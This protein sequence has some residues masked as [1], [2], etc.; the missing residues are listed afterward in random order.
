MY[1]L[2]QNTQ[3]KVA[4]GSA[5]TT[6]QMVVTVSIVDLNITT[7]AVT[8][9]LSDII[10]P[11]NG[12]TEVTI[13]GSPAAGNIR[14]IKRIEVNNQDTV[15]DTIEFIETVSGTD[16][17]IKNPIT[18]AVNNSL[19]YENNNGWYITDADGSV[20]GSLGNLNGDVTGPSSANTVVKINGAPLGST[21]P[22]SGNVL[23]ADG[24]EWKSVSLSTISAGAYKEPVFWTTLSALPSNS[25]NNGAAG[26]GATLTA[27]TNGALSIN[28]NAVSV[29]DRI[30]VNGESTPANNGI[31]VVTQTGSSG[32]PYILTRAA[33]FDTSD[34][35]IGGSLVAEVSNALDNSANWLSVWI[36]HF[37]TIPITVGTDGITFERIIPSF[38]QRA[39]GNIFQWDSNRN[40]VGNP[41]SGDATITDT[42]V[43][44]VSGIG[45]T[46]ANL[47]RL[48]DRVFRSKLEASSAA[49]TG[50]S[51]TAYFVYL[52]QTATAIT[53]KFIEGFTPS[54]GTTSV[55]E[56]G[57][58]SSP[59]PP[60]KTAQTLTKLVATTVS[61]FTSG[62][63]FRN[64]TAMS[65]S[66]PAGTY[67][68]A[69]LRVVSTT[70]PT[71]AG[72]ADD[73]T[74]GYIETQTS[75]TAFSIG[76]T[77]AGTIPTQTTFLS[78]QAPDLRVTLD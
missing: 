72:L 24:T 63:V 52:G 9:Y 60:N 3:M 26:A 21:T 40:A 51:T 30:L 58:F 48:S 71:Y 27:T 66:I 10:T 65:T 25:Y 61:A 42:G 59:A 53:P 16:K 13:C 70:N 44:T 43:V 45:G 67:L 15:Q 11:T 69:G 34:K 29:N 1:L 4:R 20:T 5:A 50:V 7:G 64:T 77:Y 41:M 56:V 38:L 36:F 2:D 6:N 14:V 12:T 75:S 74:E 35:M 49:F 55:R 57:L 22:T 19:N 28:S 8:Q 23:V 54:A 32:V 68:W 46:T 17:K 47:Q 33:D 31:Y 76:S 73:F 39:D 18:I 78:A 62:T 37:G